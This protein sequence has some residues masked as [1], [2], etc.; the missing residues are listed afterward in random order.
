M[1]C[2]TL[3]LVVKRKRVY[4]SKKCITIGISSRCRKFSQL[5]PIRLILSTGVTAA[6]TP[7]LKWP[8]T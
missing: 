7:P 3:I 1:L 5:N 6:W 2:V 8:E 4:F